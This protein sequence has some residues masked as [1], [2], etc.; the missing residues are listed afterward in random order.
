MENLTRKNLKYSN[1]YFQF[2]LIFS[3]AN[4]LSQLLNRSWTEVKMLTLSYKNQKQ[5][6]Q[7][8]RKHPK[9]SP[10]EFPF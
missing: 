9:S 1:V 8:I 5:Q 7:K 3:N 6:I 2:T 10:N 4:P